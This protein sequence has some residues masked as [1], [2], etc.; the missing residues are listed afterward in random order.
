VSPETR[1]LGRGEYGAYAA[2]L[3]R[4]ADKLD[5]SPVER[6][7]SLPHWMTRE[8]LATEAARDR[9]R[10]W[11]A[12]GS[13]TPVRHDV[14]RHAVAI[15]FDAVRQ[16]VVRAICATPPPV[17][18]FTL[19]HAWLITVA[20][21]GWTWAAAPPPATGELM[22]VALDARLGAADLRSVTGHEL[23][24]VWLLPAG[25]G[26]RVSTIAEREEHSQLLS[27][28]ASAWGRDDLLRRE[29]IRVERQAAA[30]ARQ[31]GFTG[32]PADPDACEH[33]ARYTR[34]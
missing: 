10:R 14:R 6:A 17:R 16:T 34:P 20:G 13:P 15:G 29:T 22:V 4:E 2:L 27:R 31:W 19:N 28:L 1:A 3:G 18:W 26:H 12:L 30:L 33:A 24:H 7:E 21:G 11:A 23:S 8:L 25:A 32:V 9:L 5:A